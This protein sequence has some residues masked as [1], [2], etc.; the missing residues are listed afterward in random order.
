MQKQRVFIDMDGVLAEYNVDATLEDMESEGY[1]RNLAPNSDIL[2]AV[3]YLVEENNYEVF[4]LSSVL[5]SIEK[6]AKADKN[7]WLNEYLPIIDANHRIFPLCGTDKVAAVPQFSS[8]DILCDDYSENLHKWHSAGGKAIKIL[9]GINGNN[10][11]FKGLRLKIDKK[12]QLSNTIKM[13]V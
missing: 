3:K 11:T 5:P 8:S 10:G 2:A 7:A 4:V 9:N 1:F 6:S 12:D 13:A